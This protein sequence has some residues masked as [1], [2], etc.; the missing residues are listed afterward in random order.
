M[1]NQVDRRRLL[2]GAIAFIAT[3]ICPVMRSMAYANSAESSANTTLFKKTEVIDL[4][5]HDLS[6]AKQQ[7]KKILEAEPI[8]MP[9]EFG[10]PD[11][12]AVHFPAGPELK[13][14]MYSFGLFQADPK[15][16]ERATLL[17]LLVYDL[18]KAIAVLK[19]RGIQFDMEQPRPY[20]SGRG[21]TTAPINGFQ[22]WLAQHNTD[23]YETW[24]RLP[25]EPWPTTP[26]WGPQ[27]FKRVLSVGL[28]VKNLPQAINNYEKFLGTPPVP[29]QTDLYA[30]R[31]VFSDFEVAHFDL[32]GVET[33]LQALG[34]YQIKTQSPSTPVGKSVKRFLD[35]GGEG[36]F[37][38]GILVDK[39]NEAQ[40]ALQERGIKFLNE[41]PQGYAAGRMNITE[42]I[43]GVMC[44]IVE[45]SPDA[46]RRWKGAR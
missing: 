21:I 17:G 10:T 26:S 35:A 38:I 44:A 33:D 25:H 45:Q 11:M 43:T 20:A 3:G 1:D 23:G 18:D 36:A 15:V 8:A 7:W 28:A 13:N 12:K 9:Q 42:P 34:L 24:A 39:A 16:S 37:M 5:V 4:L 6:S 14:G 41:R 2:G 40:R 29:Q 31:N 27:G 30:A 22:F 19:S 46:Y 32:P